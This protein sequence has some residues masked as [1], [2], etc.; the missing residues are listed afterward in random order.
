M[1]FVVRRARPADAA[2][3]AAVH[4][5]TW[6]D[7]YR[8]VVAAD[9]LAA[10]DVHDRTAHWRDVLGAGRA[11]TLVAVAHD[12]R[13]DGGDDDVVFGFASFGPTRDADM[14]GAGELYQIYVSS[15][16]WRAG[17]G[18][19]LLAEAVDALAALDFAEAALW[20]LVDNPRARAFYEAH[21]WRSDDRDAG[22]RGVTVGPATGLVE[23]RDRRALGGA[24]KSA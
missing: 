5:E 14:A 16:R 20:V 6:R 4:V 9:A 18:S 17:A 19:S 7:A 21:G 12:E 23:M 11:H 10:L 2:G 3:I 8:G 15:T 1:A 22:L 13:D 24:P